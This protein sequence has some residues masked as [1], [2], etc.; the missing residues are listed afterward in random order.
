MFGAVVAAV[1]SGVLVGL[2][3][4]AQ[5]VSDDLPSQVDAVDA[6]GREL[7]HQAW[8]YAA[9]PPVVR[10][11]PVWPAPGTARV[12]LSKSARTA[13]A[14]SRAGTLPVFVGPAR[15]AAVG[16]R[17]ATAAASQVDI[18][19][20]DR[21]IMPEEWRN[22]VVL[23]LTTPDATPGAVRVA[24]DYA[25]FRWALGA[26]WASRLQMYQLPECALIADETTD[27]AAVALPS[28]H[29]QATRVAADVVVG[30]T[31][32][33]AS[34][35]SASTGTVVALAAGATGGN[36][37]FA[38]TS[39]SSAATW[40]AGGN[41]GGF[42]W[43]YPMRVPPS[44][45][46]LSP[47]LNVSYSSGSVDGRNEATNNQ[48]SWLGEGFD[49]WPGYIER[50]YVS[51][52]DDTDE[53]QPGANNTRRTGDLCWRTDNA[54]MSLNGSGGELV[55]QDGKGWHSRTEDG[56]KIERK[57]GAG[58]GDDDGE[59]W[60]VTSADGTQYFFGLHS[61]P[62]QSARTN[63]AWTVPVAGNHD[64][65]ACNADTFAKSF[66]DQAWRWN[67]DYVVD[68]RGNTIS[69]WYA[70]E[71]NKYARNLKATDAVDY[72]RGGHLE[73]IDYGTWDRGTGSGERSVTPVSQVVFTDADR[74]VTS[75]C[76]KHNATNWP[77][78]PWDQNCT[79]S[80][81]NGKW[82]PTFWSTKR[83]A[84][85]TS[86]VWDTT[87]NPAKW[88]P[89]DSWTFTHSFPSA[90][91]GSAHDGLWLDQIVHAGHVG[92]DV[93]LPPVTFTPI[94][95]PNRVLTMNTS[96]VNWQRIDYIISETGARIDVEWDDAECTASRLPAN[97]HAN[98]M[99]CY[100]VRVVDPDD[101]A[102]KQYIDEWWHKH[103]VKSVSESDSPTDPTGHQAPP[104]F[105]T[106]EY[107]GSPAWRYGDDDGLSHPKR[108]TWDQ[109]RG[110]AAV[111]TRV[112]EAPGKQT[113]T[114]TK[115]LRGMH[116]NRSA[117]AG[118][119]DTVTVG[120]SIG[121]ETVYD[122]DQFAGITREETVYN[123]AESKPVSRTVNV[124]W[125]SEPTAERTINK[126]VVSARFADT[127]TTYQATALG[128][129]GAGGWRTT[130]IRKTFNE[131]YGS[132]ERTDDAGDIAKPGDEKCITYSYNRNVDKR[133][134]NTVK[135]TTTTT[136]PCGT[137][138][139]GPEHV[140]S[141]VR[142]YYDGATNVNTAPVYGSVTKAETLNDWTP[143]GGT[144]WQTTGQYTFDDYGRPLSETDLKGNVLNTSYT[145]AAGGPV[146]KVTL[147][148][149]APFNWTSS[150]EP[151]PY[152]G[153]SKVSTDQN[154]GVTTVHYDPL[155][156]V[157]RAWKLGWRNA[158]HPTSPSVEYGYHYAPDRNEYPYV[159]SKV[160]NA[161]GGYQTSYQIYDSLLRPRQTQTAGVGGGRIVSDTLYDDHGRAVTTYSPHV[162]PGT[163]SGR[164]WW[165]PEWSV[166]SINRTVFDNA[167]RPTDQ[168]FLSGDGTENLVVQW[169]TRTDYEGNLTKVTPPAGG[170]A[171]TMV[172]DAQGRTVEL[173]QH[174]TAAGVTGAHQS[175]SYTYNAKGQLT[176]VTDPA[177]NR[178]EYRFDIKGRQYETNDP[179]KG[180]VQTQYNQYNEVEKT[181]D[182]RG[183][184]LWHTYD[185]LGRKAE[186]REGSATGPL[187]AAWK[188]DKLFS[189]STAGAKGQLTEAWRYEPAGSANIYKWQVG[190]F[191]E[192]VQPTSIN[193]VVPTVEGAELGRTWTVGAS[194]SAYDGSPVGT[195]YPAGGGLTNEQTDI[196]YDRVT[197]L[198]LR[199][200]TTVLFEDQY[201]SEQKYTVY[202]E[203]TVTTRE[204]A[205]SVYVQDATY[206]DTYTRRVKQTMVKPETATG[207]VSDRSY[208]YQDAGN[209]LGIADVPAV[210]P[211]DR[212]CFQED[213]LGRLVTAWTPATAVDC[214]TATPSLATLGGP[215]EYWLDWTIDAVGNR[216]KETS[217]ARA[218]DTV[219]DF[220]LPA[221]G[222]GA[223]R[224]HA[225]TQVTTKAPNVAAVVTNY[226]YNDTGDTV[227]RP[228]DTKANTCSP[229]GGAQQLT[230]DAEGEL[231]AVANG[232]TT[233]ETNVH[234]ADGTRWLRR[235]ATGTTLYLPGQEIR[236]GTDGK[237]TGTRYYGFAGRT[238]GMRTSE[239]LTWLYTDHQG[240]QHT[241]VDARTQKVTSRRQLPYGGM[242]TTSIWPNQKGFV[243]GD[244]DPTGLTAIGARHYDPALGRFISV[245]P[246]MDMASP[247][248]H[249]G[250]SYANNS[251]IS[252]SDPTGLDPGGGQCVDT[253]RCTPGGDPQAPK[254][255][256]K[257]KAVKI[258]IEQIIHRG[259][260]TEEYTKL[261]SQWLRGTAFA[262]LAPIHKVEVL[263]QYYCENKIIDCA[264][265]REQESAAAQAFL[266]SASGYTDA[267]QCLGGSASGC[268][269]TVIGVMPLGKAKALKLTDEFIDL[270]EAGSKS[271]L[272][273]RIAS[274]AFKSFSGDTKV[275]MGDG[276][277]KPI[278]DIKV[279]DKVLAT[280]PKTG[281]KSPRKVTHVWVHEDQL[282]DLNLSNGDHVTT[283]DD[284][285]FWNETDSQWQE[286][287]Q[288]S[289]DDR[290]LTSTPAVLRVKGLNW[291]TSRQG[292]AYNLTVADIHTYYVLA[293]KTPVLVHNTDGCEVLYK[294]P[295]KGMADKLLNDGFDPADFPGSGNGF[296][297]G[298]AYFGLNDTGREIA[299]DYASRGGYDNAV[300]Q[301]RIP[302]AD[303][304]EHFRQYIGSHN[305][306]PGSEV[307]IPNTVFDRLNQYPRSV[308]P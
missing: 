247:Q 195:F 119:A 237:V 280:D 298:R 43:S 218:G 300:I 80:K 216:K 94:A 151:N 58:N 60:K 293:G 182:A 137:A 172:T 19:V 241:T 165:E 90:G 118:G 53:D 229:P 274:C 56:S 252:L 272:G 7:G 304:D 34:A 62:G 113:L 61:P 275:L 240:T 136:L 273:E 270:A 225:V 126:D 294:A 146:T 95:L 278:K 200:I 153:S 121:G 222:P 277:A 227:C 250:Y 83:L 232:A 116:G 234:G 114:V 122:Q 125:R 267:E 209:M 51:C 285:P 74:C 39:L 84:K 24:V 49:Y 157:W 279:G 120:A 276:S 106:Y 54:T 179:D 268:V 264:K 130:R 81:C 260:V 197:G 32:S 138:P 253:P 8:P 259:G 147:T 248:Q 282:V 199:L 26:D 131:D 104:T 301:V 129:D 170:T 70:R 265:V 2:P 308:V 167:D 296:P 139:T 174:T 187:R 48:P 219:R 102:G 41:S 169:R 284:H 261:D 262:D 221:G 158:D 109:F 86:Q 107:V 143:A 25:Q 52:A 196:K 27:C 258:T 190:G 64:R 91:D 207:T 3:T 203:P 210:G 236:R 201:V 149:P 168:I 59:Y 206:Y 159:S 226:S 204:T 148:R 223:V 89:V 18:E 93:A 72:H 15:V 233:V 263:R 211:A 28:V 79:G 37:D 128:A 12:A 42:S 246:V 288:L 230:W 67:L 76:G 231:A 166:P 46:S 202:G 45:G 115:Y 22:G 127:Q 144:T 110:Y 156:R 171:T 180:R 287:R 184:S 85:I 191:S 44:I 176:R 73:R 292:L 108:R 50:R 215:N 1:L 220:T 208:Q 238:I 306:V 140:L 6:D 47:S 185:A 286:A 181:S 92:G 239:G 29:E 290:L 281:K 69:Y 38:A 302:K 160:L 289:T 249:H 31:G 189:G 271:A 269:W 254:N 82:S 155:G 17:A 16:A 192:R 266:L 65:E 112:G 57:T 78:T 33:G 71:T 198:P 135:Q 13:S 224:P 245:D 133:L 117:P 214:K 193:Y 150:T 4:E 101:P 257:P 66:C 242:R 141:D 164:L 235:D 9:P 134:L 105:T 251:P 163:P 152:W 35:R 161:G 299:L 21:D 55:F 244:N 177:D 303:F 88:Q 297:D 213:H 20:L 154:K 307:A 98:T 256:G 291:G 36:G 243:G 75:S 255:Q 11:E 111:K 283:T 30:A 305:G 205:G 173:R 194:Y 40:S 123:G 14:T 100:P 132:V 175:T 142:S 5:A 124:P 178:W 63:S 23:R 103:R 96:T 217:H 77:D 87:Q 10:P 295:G 186:L 99:R 188:Y 228:V 97:A 212:Q 183:V 145:P 68:V 162:E